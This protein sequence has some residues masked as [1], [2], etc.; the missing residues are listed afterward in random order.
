MGTTLLWHSV[1]CE[2]DFWDGSGKQGM[3]WARR[4][5]CCQLGG[6]G[7]GGAEARVELSVLVWFKL[8]CTTSCLQEL[9]PV[10]GQRLVSGVVLP[11]PSHQVNNFIP[12][13]EDRL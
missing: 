10:T 5:G 4:G 12:P 7:L 1:S 2:T 6:V 3:C 11:Q 8:Q 13:T 9:S